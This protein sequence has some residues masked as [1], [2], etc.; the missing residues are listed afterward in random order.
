MSSSSSTN[1]ESDFCIREL[2]LC[3]YEKGFLDCLKELTIVGEISKEMFRKTF[4][5]RKNRDVFTIVAVD[6]KSDRILGTGSVFYE[7]KFIRECSVKA[8]IEDISVTK[9]AQ[10]R[11][12][13]RE[14]VKY[15]EHKA[16]ND[17]CYKIILTCNE[18]NRGF[19][20]KMNFEQKEYAMAYYSNNSK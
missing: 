6:K 8:Y 20:K 3:D 2:E 16:L 19:Y 5:D 11:G 4:F 10:G 15:L 14:I 12:I 17:G 18:K 13:G 7:P 9:D 1:N